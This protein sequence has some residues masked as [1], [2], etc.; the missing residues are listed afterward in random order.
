ME[1]DTENEAVLLA[2]RRLCPDG[3]CV[4]ILGSDGRCRL[5]GMADPGWTTG[6]PAASTHPVST[7]VLPS[8]TPSSVE[9]KL[10]GLSAEETRIYE[11]VEALRKR[12]NELGLPELVARLVPSMAVWPEWFETRRNYV[13]RVAQSIEKIGDRIRIDLD[14]QLIEF[15]F[16]TRTVDF[17]D[18][19][20]GR[21]AT[22]EVFWNGKRAF[23][24]SMSGREHYYHVEWLV[25]RVD[26]FI[27]GPWVEI[28]F[29]LDRKL[30]EMKMA[31]E[32]EVR[33]QESARKHD[34]QK[35]DFGIG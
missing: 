15:C 3:A 25:D 8:S 13:H 27:E 34:Q 2:N 6:K 21:Y 32:D 29:A 18:N 12:A 7:A 17:P 10:D 35:K 9:G 30:G 5:C 19:R 26:A 1:N 11:A 31:W 4:G 24:L 16:K 14:G 33:K 20:L 28:L 23:S 22:A